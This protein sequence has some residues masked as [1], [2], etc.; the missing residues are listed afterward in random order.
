MGRG[1]DLWGDL[2]CLLLLV[3]SFASSEL[4]AT[5]IFCVHLVLDHEVSFLELLNLLHENVDALIA[6][7][8]WIYKDKIMKNRN[9]EEFSTVLPSST[10]KLNCILPELPPAS[11]WDRD[12][13]NAF[14]SELS[15]L[16]ESVKIKWNEI[17]LTDF[18][19]ANWNSPLPCKLPRTFAFLGGWGRRLFCCNSVS[20][21]IVRFFFFGDVSDLLTEIKRKHLLLVRPRI[22]LIKSPTVLFTFR[23]IVIRVP[24]RVVGIVVCVIATARCTSTLWFELIT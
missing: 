12:D 22:L 19:G 14:T 9:R 2:Y 17:A 11:D 24:R 23:L 1:L 8:I 13:E 7:K 6:W 18:P 20:C 21:F 3:L 10:K 4:L 15:L 16:S 5:T